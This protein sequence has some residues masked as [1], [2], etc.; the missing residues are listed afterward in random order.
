MSM[1]IQ[2]LLKMLKRLTDAN[3]TGE[4]RLSFYKGSISKKIKQ[5]EA[6]TLD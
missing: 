1:Q 2:T 5:V 4:V 6:V 3:F